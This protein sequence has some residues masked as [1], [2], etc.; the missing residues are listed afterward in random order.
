MPSKN[1]VQPNETLEQQKLGSNS[2]ENAGVEAV[3]SVVQEISESAQ[4]VLG[5]AEQPHESA[6]QISDN[7]V[8]ANH[9]KIHYDAKTALSLEKQIE[10]MSEQRL[11]HRIR[12]E[13][14][15]EIKQLE[16][17]AFLAGL[18]F[19]HFSESAFNEL[20]A[21]IRE[22]QRKIADLVNLAIETLRVIYRG[23]VFGE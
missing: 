4:E 16:H 1:L 22:L 12:N 2:A 8:Y 18:P 17:Q 14:Q 5:E 6:E 23:L 19:A 15:K 10:Q 9:R 13:Y 11:R 3:S 7:I 20:V 21:R